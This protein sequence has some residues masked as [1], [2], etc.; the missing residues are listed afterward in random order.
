MSL[1]KYRVLEIWNP[2]ILPSQVRHLRVGQKGQVSFV[3]VWAQNLIHWKERKTYLRL[4]WKDG[5]EW[6]ECG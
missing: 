2:R 3:L 6:R 1:Y 4:I 5:E